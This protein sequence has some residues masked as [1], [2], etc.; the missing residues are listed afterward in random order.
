MRVAGVVP[1][2]P[3]GGQFHVKRTWMRIGIR[4]FSRMS[5]IKMGVS[6]DQHQAAATWTVKK[7]YRC[8]VEGKR[9]SS[10]SCC[11]GRE[12]IAGFSQSAAATYRAAK[13]MRT[14]LQLYFNCI[15]RKQGTSV[16]QRVCAPA[17]GSAAM[18]PASTRTAE[19]RE[20]RRQ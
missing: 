9:K 14:A 3:D 16:H 2:A 6:P 4:T 7:P 12:G 19:Q 10:R 1:Y 5:R 13:D 15:H 17:L 20:L 11:R 18:K 8:Y